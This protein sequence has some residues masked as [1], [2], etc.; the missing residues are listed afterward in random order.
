M[1]AKP[2]RH[3]LSQSQ[4]TASG[5]AGKAELLDG[6]A[7]VVAGLPG[8]LGIADDDWIAQGTADFLRAGVGHPAFRL[9]K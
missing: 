1:D 2:H 8:L 5:V 9:V 4:R 7:S 6:Q 3:N